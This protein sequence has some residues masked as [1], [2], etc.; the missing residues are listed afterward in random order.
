MSDR[1]TIQNELSELGSDLPVT[2]G[3]VFSVP[4]GY[5]EGLA[6]AALAKVKTADDLQPQA[7]LEALSPFLAGMPKATPYSVPPLYFQENTEI[8]SAL[9]AEP[10][11]SVL[12]GHDKRMPYA[13]PAGY[14]NTLPAQVLAKVAEPKAKVVPLFARTWMRVAAAAVV[15]GALVIGGLTIFNNRPDDASLAANAANDTTLVAQSR[16][17]IEQEIKNVP[18]QELEQFIADVVP[19]VG[20][21][22]GQTAAAE[23][24][25]DVL[26]EDVSVTEM[27][28]FLSALPQAEYEIGGT[29]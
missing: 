3:S 25:A 18:T 21:N 13:V 9:G 12:A 27:E 16:P 10:A 6:A 26:L 15:A 11:P 29:D 23:K 2:D 4:E 14:F 1:K 19:P 22:A 8:L 17:V 20:A 7:E 24:E 28:S 5:F